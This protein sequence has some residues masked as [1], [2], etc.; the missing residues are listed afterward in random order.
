MAV[1]GVVFRD[2]LGIVQ[3]LGSVEEVRKLQCFPVPTPLPDLGQWTLLDEEITRP[4][5]DSPK[6][7]TGRIARLP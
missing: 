7:L 4:I 3:P 1:Y 5:C 6:V 2:P